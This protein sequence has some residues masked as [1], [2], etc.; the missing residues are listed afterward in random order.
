MVPKFPF[1]DLEITPVS[2][3]SRAP[4]TYHAP[5]PRVDG[6]TGTRRAELWNDNVKG[7]AKRSEQKNRLEDA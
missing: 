4:V 5:R 6:L 1:V 3:S 2:S 7:R